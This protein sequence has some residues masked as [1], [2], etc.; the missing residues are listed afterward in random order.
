MT[1]TIRPAHRFACRSLATAVLTYC[2]A[3]FLNQF[4]P[5]STARHLAAPVSLQ[6]LSRA[7][8]SG[9]RTQALPQAASALEK[10]TDKTDYSDPPTLGAQKTPR[11][12]E[13]QSQVLVVETK[14]NSHHFRFAQARAPPL[15]S[16]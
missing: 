2:F 4:A 7:A 10:R 13:A 5:T 6:D 9:H 14:V 1:K 15:F 16:A 8:A 12:I 11:V 3:L